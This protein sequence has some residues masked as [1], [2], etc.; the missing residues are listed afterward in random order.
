MPEVTI[1][2]ADLDKVIADFETADPQYTTLE[3]RGL[4]ERL[5]QRRAKPHC[6][7]PDCLKDAEFSIH[8]SS[9]DFEDVT[10]ACEEH[11]GALLGT[12]AHLEK[13]NDHW[14]VHPIAASVAKV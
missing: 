13:E 2:S 9:G 4:L 3:E 1:D 6:C 14:V 11:A 10:E 8:G 5:K 12:P 7:F